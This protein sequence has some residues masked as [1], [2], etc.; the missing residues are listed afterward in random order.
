[1]IPVYEYH[2]LLSRV[3][4]CVIILWS[5]VVYTLLAFLFKV[6][7]K[8]P[9]SS[10]SY[11]IFQQLW[12]RSNEKFVLQFYIISQINLRPCTLVI[13]TDFLEVK[14]SL[15]RSKSNNLFVYAIKLSQS[16]KVKYQQ[17][18]FL[19]LRIK[20]KKEVIQYY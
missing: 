4:N 17:T 5:I 11:H 18:S 3:K 2:K 7:Y 19:R 6:Q 10:I 14:E 9:D 12:A 15:F 8:A 20:N 1:M 16:Y 13:L